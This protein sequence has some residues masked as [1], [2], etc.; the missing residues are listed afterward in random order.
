VLLHVFREPRS[1]NRAALAFAHFRTVR[2]TER[3]TQNCRKKMGS[4]NV[5]GNKKVQFRA[6]FILA[7]CQRLCIFRPATNKDL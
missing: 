5:Q 1:F 4:E 6:W 7:G 2:S 3:Q